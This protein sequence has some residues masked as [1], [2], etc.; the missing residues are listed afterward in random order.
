[1][2]HRFPQRDLF[3]KEEEEKR[4]SVQSTPWPW[5]FKS[6]FYYDL[7]LTQN[8]NMFL[9]KKKVIWKGCS[10]NITVCLPTT[11]DLG[12][13]SETTMLLWIPSVQIN[14]PYILGE[15]IKHLHRPFSFSSWAVFWWISADNSFFLLQG[16]HGPVMLND[17]MAELS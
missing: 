1:M 13:F 3:E 9:R 12:K 5:F 6:Y 15:A 10:N 16:I 8:E 11:F 14:Q 17:P 4:S 2:Y 7:A